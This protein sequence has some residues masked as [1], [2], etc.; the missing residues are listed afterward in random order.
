MSSSR[1]KKHTV[2]NLTIR[3]ASIHGQVLNVDEKGRVEALQSEV[4]FIFFEAIKDSEEYT[5]K[6]QNTLKETVRII[7]ERLRQEDHKE[8]DYVALFYS[9]PWFFSDLRK[10][11]L[12]PD[13]PVVF[14]QKTMED[15]LLESSGE[16]KTAYRDNQNL[17]PIE[18]HISNINLNGYDLINPYGKEYSIGSITLLTT[19]VPRN[20]QKKII[21]TI[22][23][24]CQHTRILH[25]SFPYSL[26]TT[27]ET[28]SQMRF[29]VLDVH[30]EI[31]DVIFMQN[32]IIESIQSVPVGTNHLLK[33]MNE[34][35]FPSEKAKQDFLEMIRQK[36]IDQ[37]TSDVHKN[38]CE[39]EILRWYQSLINIPYFKTT[40]DYIILA[41]EPFKGLFKECL[42]KEKGFE[43]LSEQNTFEND[44]VF[45]QTALFWS[46]Y[47]FLHP[48]HLH[49]LQK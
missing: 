15:I 40:D 32:S 24:I 31:T 22:Q 42:E 3:S 18:Q 25:F 49:R 35:S 48:E 10:F 11:D 36:Y 6:I 7:V 33:K 12:T 4:Q 27:I 41:Q 9:S 19:W 44:H 23:G 34:K 1:L 26:I 8:V 29:C 14:S 39:A 17:R 47:T 30:E 2:L 28:N 45:Q 43:P 16:L 13:K 37:K 20:F 5:L 38:V 21:E 46:K